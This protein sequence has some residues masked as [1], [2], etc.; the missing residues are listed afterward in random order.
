MHVGNKVFKYVPRNRIITGT[1]KSRNEENFL[2]NSRKNSGNKLDSRTLLSNC[3]FL[4]LLY[5][6]II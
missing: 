1:F 2:I 5:S 6:K 4:W 3:Y